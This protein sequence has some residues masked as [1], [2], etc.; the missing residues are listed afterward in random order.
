MNGSFVT[1]TPLKRINNALLHA[2][3]VLLRLLLSVSRAQ[4]TTDGSLRPAGPIKRPTYI[5]AGPWRG[6]L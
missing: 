4:I 2:A 5:L 1:R 3:L 6:G